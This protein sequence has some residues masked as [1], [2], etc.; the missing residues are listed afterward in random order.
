MYCPTCPLQQ[1]ID[2]SKAEYREQQRQYTRT[3][4]QQA[5][6]E[7][8]KTMVIY[9]IGAQWQYGEHVPAGCTNAEVV[10]KTET[11]LL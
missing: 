3:L 8:Q 9:K 7:Q 2:R 1:A 5:A 4:A 6:N 10:L 11:V